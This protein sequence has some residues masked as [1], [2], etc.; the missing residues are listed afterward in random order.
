MNSTRDRNSTAGLVL[1]AVGVVAL[2]GSLGVVR[3][4]AD[5]LGAL[6]F[7][8]LA[9]LAWA[10]GRRR[11]SDFWRLAALP[12]LGLAVASIAP[13]GLGDGA[14][15]ASLGLAFA[16]YWHEDRRRWWALIPAG[17]L[18]T[19]AL[20]DSLDGVLRPVPG[21]IF[22]AGMA[23]TFFALTRLEVEPQPW[24]I[25]PAAGLGLVALMSVF[26]GGGWLLP[27]LLIGAGAFLLLRQ[28]EPFG[29]RVRVERRGPEA[30]SEGAVQ[31][32]APHAEPV[33]P[34]PRQEGAR[35]AGP[36]PA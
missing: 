30:P 19:L 25:W 12:L 22:F 27:L 15:L 11:G 32:P 24:A 1:I 13:F 5:L 18:A 10:E 36:G 26:D 31:P 34:A 14:F 2:L 17:T 23:L 9:Y 20:I 35:D 8:G 28:G 6:L 29:V 4:M 3:F 33:P 16:V 21:W 7:G